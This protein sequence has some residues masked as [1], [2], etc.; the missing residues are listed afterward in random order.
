M[1]DLTK[2]IAD[3]RRLDAEATPGPATVQ[4]ALMPTDGEYDCAIRLD[5]HL[6]L[7]AFG[8]CST[9]RFLPAKANANLIAHARNHHAALW[10]L[11]EAAREMQRLWDKKGRFNVVEMDRAAKNLHA[12]LACLEQVQP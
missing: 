6:A 3:A 10:D 1:T 7:E 2:K 8:R 4:E 12:A 5:G 9:M 11:V